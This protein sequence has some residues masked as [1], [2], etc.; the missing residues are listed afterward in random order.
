MSS[1]AGQRAICKLSVNPFWM[2]FSPPSDKYLVCHI[3]HRLVYDYHYSQY[4]VFYTR[5]IIKLGSRSTALQHSTNTGVTKTRNQIA[6]LVICNGILFLLCQMP[7]RA[8]S[9][10]RVLQNMSVIGQIP[11]N[12]FITLNILSSAVLFNSTLNSL[13]YPIM[14]PFY[15]QAYREAFCGN[16]QTLQRK[17]AASTCS[18][19]WNHQYKKLNW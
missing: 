6:K 16:R 18:R 4:T 8:A 12:M 3:Q 10:I 15:R 17:V 5:M 1:L 11:R 2:S 9:V 19:R 7:Y 13:V 14:S